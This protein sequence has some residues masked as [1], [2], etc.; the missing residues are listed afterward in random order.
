MLLTTE[1]QEITP[2]KLQPMLIQKSI[3]YL[4]D[5]KTKTKREKLLNQI[6]SQ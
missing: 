3:H 4:T 1:N 5:F 6:G 2:N